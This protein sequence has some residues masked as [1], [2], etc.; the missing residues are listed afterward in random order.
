LDAGRGFLA[1][2]SGGWHFGHVAYS[3]AKARA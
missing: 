1:K 2:R 3:R